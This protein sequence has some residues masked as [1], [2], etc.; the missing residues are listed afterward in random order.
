MTEVH[1]H[2][3]THTHTHAHTHKHTHTHT[4][5]VTEV[6]LLTSLIYSEQLPRSSSKC[7]RVLTF[8]NI[9]Q[10]TPLICGDG[11]TQ[12]E[13]E[14]ECD[15]ANTLDGDG[16]SS[17]CIVE[18]DWH[19]FHCQIEDNLCNGTGLFYSFVGLFCSFIGLF[20]ALF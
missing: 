5:C 7:T 15:D 3:H 4:H 9:F 19:C 20:P 2:T 6:Q 1:K 8:E 10:L 14:E 16:C 11:I 18:R 13:L 17:D 12:K